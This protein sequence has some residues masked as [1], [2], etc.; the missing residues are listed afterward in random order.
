MNSYPIGIDI[1]IGADL[2]GTLIFRLFDGIWKGSEHEPTVQNTTLGWI[3]SRSIASFP[4]TESISTLAHHR[5]VLE[6]LDRDLRRFWEIEEV[7]QKAPRNLEKHQCKEHTLETHSHREGRYIVR[8][9]LK[10]SIDESLSIAVSSFRRLE[11]TLNSRL[12]LLRTANFSQ[13]TKHSV[14]WPKVHQQKLSNQS[15]LIIFRIMMSYETA[16]QLPAY[17]SS[18]LQMP[19]IESSTFHATNLLSANHGL[20]TRV[21]ESWFSHSDSLRQRA[22]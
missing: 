7:P 14:I 12:M 3:L 6:I 21:R 19:H 9:R 8:L 2:F 11:S 4:T 13:N 10:I 17:E 16:V 1:I 18:T 20:A 15:K 22:P 5:V